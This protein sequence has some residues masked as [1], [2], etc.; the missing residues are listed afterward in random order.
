VDS[1][2]LFYPRHFLL[3]ACFSL[4]IG[5]MSQLQLTGNLSVAFAL[6][7]A[8]HAVALVLAVRSR[9]DIWRKCL[10]IGFAAALCVMTFHFGSVAR[11]QSAALPGK[12][13]LYFPLGLS[14]FIGA[15]SYGT[16]IRLSG[17]YA[18]TMGKLAAIAAGCAFAA[19]FSLFTAGH[20]HFLGPWWLA[21]FWWFTF[22][23]GLWYFDRRRGSPET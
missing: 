3:L 6:Y 17:I 23:G 9:Q 8:L 19:Y 2:A 20:F 11:E 22:S 16:V 18:L 7:G 15:A 1:K 21:V 13:G 4:L 5:V 14:A 12:V 10:F